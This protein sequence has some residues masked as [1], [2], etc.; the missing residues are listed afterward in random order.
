MFCTLPLQFPPPSATRKE[1]RGEVLEA[2]IIIEAGD[3]V[4]KPKI[5]CTM[6][7]VPTSTVAAAR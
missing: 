2:T 4:T 6:H 7:S 3:G 1:E 5:P